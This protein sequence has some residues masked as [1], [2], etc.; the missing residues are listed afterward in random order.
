M[1]FCG[2]KNGVK[3]GLRSYQILKINGH[4]HILTSRLL[5][6]WFNFFLEEKSFGL[7]FNKCF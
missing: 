1:V 2:E 6:F 7:V 4:M 3:V 5:K